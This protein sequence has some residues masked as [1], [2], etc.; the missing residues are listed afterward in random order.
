MSLTSSG[1]TKYAS[2]ISF[3][4]DST[5][6]SSTTSF[7]VLEMGEVGINHSLDTLD[8][9]FN[10]RVLFDLGTFT[11]RVYDIMANG[12][13]FFN[14]IDSEVTDATERIFVKIDVTTRVGARSFTDRWYFT[15]KDMS[16][17][18]DGRYVSLECRTDF[19]YDITNSVKDYFGSSFKNAT[20]ISYRK[21]DLSTSNAVVVG[22]FIDDVLRMA[23]QDSTRVNNSANFQDRNSDTDL[24]TK[25]TF[26]VLSQ[27]TQTVQSAF[28]QLAAAE[29]SVVGNCLGYSYFTPR[30]T[31][32]AET[33]STSD[34]DKGSFS[35]SVGYNVYRGISVQFR[36]DGSYFGISGTSEFKDYSESD[37]GVRVSSAITE[38]DTRFAVE[39]SGGSPVAEDTI[40]AGSIIWFFDGN[41]QNVAFVEKQAQSVVYLSAPIEFDVPALRQIRTVRLFNPVG[42]KALSLAYVTA[43]VAPARRLTASSST[44]DEVSSPSVDVVGDSIQRYS[45][46]YSAEG[47]RRITM[48]ILGIE[49]IKPHL[50]VTLDSSFD[51]QYRGTYFISELSA[52]YMTDK[53]T[54]TLHEVF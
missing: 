17:S 41:N 49:K 4:V 23:N 28:F 52:D 12:S 43:C 33:I 7:D 42:T 54:V 47:Q 13:S 27:P 18:G 37:S 9:D 53:V 38:G 39:T 34:V 14:T 40:P 20:T 16:M 32:G 5:S 19:E 25:D 11:F 3:T 36:L 29:G 50:P 2:S 51:A 10:N 1:N 22:D 35:V 15:K 31:T 48:T 44:Y 46:A 26:V 8:A 24:A 21:S 6:L 45:N 30:T